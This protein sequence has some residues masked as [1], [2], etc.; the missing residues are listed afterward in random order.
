MAD[1]CRVD[2]VGV[3]STMQFPDQCLSLCILSVCFQT[4]CTAHSIITVH[5]PICQEL[6]GASTVKLL[7][8]P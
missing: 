8:G 6:V 1:A 4:F 3:F 5:D 2:G 7:D